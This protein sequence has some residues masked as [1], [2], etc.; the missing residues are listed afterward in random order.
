M[1]TM[2]TGNKG[3]TLIEMAIVLIIIGII[4]GA[5]VKGRDI[6]KSGEQKRIYTKFFNEWRMA[7]LNFYDRTGKRLGD[8]W[9]TANAGSVGQDGQ[10]DTAAGTSNAAPTEDGRNNLVSGDNG[11]TPLYYGLNQVGLNEPISNTGIAWMYRFTDSSGTAH[12]ITIAFDYQATNN[13]NYMLISNIP[14]ELCM[15][16]DT[17]IDGHADGNDG[18]FID[19]GTTGWGTSPSAVNTAWWKMEF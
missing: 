14:N 9:D 19:N 10:A 15:A 17:I 4:I 6:I 5:V 12:D 7:Y 8:T 3:F 1:K 2:F 11:T 16:L 18:D 13:Y